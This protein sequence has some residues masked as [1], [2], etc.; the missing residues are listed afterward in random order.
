MKK[1]EIP[2][3]GS[4]GTVWD[5]DGKEM[6]QRCACGTS[7]PSCCDV[8]M[9][10]SGWLRHVETISEFISDGSVKEL[11]GKS[12][13]EVEEALFDLVSLVETNTYKENQ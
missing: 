8:T 7:P 5:W 11:E 10:G 12:P 9:V 13:K 6:F 1:I 3:V 4:H 2:E